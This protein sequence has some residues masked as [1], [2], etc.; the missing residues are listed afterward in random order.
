[1]RIWA[2]IGCERMGTKEKSKL[3]KRLTCSL[4][5]MKS[6]IIIPEIHTEIE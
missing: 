1:M 4:E 3:G 5:E 6:K 2:E